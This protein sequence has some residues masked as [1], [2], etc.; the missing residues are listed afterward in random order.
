M[1]GVKSFDAADYPK[2][3]GLLLLCFRQPNPMP[4]ILAAV[5]FPP[6]SV[7]ATAAFSLDSGAT[8][9]AASP[10]RFDDKAPPARINQAVFRQQSL[11]NAASAELSP[12]VQPLRR[13]NCQDASLR[14]F[15][16]LALDQCRL[17]YFSGCDGN[18]NNF[19]TLAECEV[20]CK[21]GFTPNSAPAQQQLQQQQKVNIG[22]CPSGELP[23]GGKNP[24]LCGDRSD[25]IGCPS[26]FFCAD[27]PPSVCCP[28]HKSAASVGDVR[29]KPSIGASGGA[30]K[31]LEVNPSDDE[32]DDA[33]RTTPTTD[34][35]L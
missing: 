24:V 10:L 28:G 16:D 21:I 23:L 7:S 34:W 9:P 18:E 20:R 12:C 29:R 22:P 14:Y 33:A 25:S 4:Q 35:P 15:Y 3:I 5:F 31:Q 32:E 6:R 27:G 17:F 13:G 19:A 8:A 11:L 1:E 2:P 30:E 26:G